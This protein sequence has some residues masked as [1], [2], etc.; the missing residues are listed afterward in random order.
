MCARLIS[1]VAC[2]LLGSSGLL[3]AQPYREQTD[4][5]AVREQGLAFG[6]HMHTQGL[7]IDG[8]YFRQLFDRFQGALHVSAASL[9]DQREVRIS[10]LYASQG[11]K[12]FIYD[13]KNHVYTLNAT[14]SLQRTLVPLN[15]YN[16]LNVIAGLGAGPAI[17]LLKPYY[18]EVAVPI[19]ATQARVELYPYDAS[20]FGYADIVGRA[21]FFQGMNEL[22]T[23]MG[24]RARAFAH[25]NLAGSTLYLR[26]IQLGGTVDVYGRALEIMDEQ[27][28]RQ[29]FANLYLGLLFGNA[30]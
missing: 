30:W 24:F 17:A 14:L 19:N 10:S 25:I 11:G 8:Y 1:F 9:R 12:D 29:V 26:S 22:R 2:L 7:G 4:N 13:K 28:D 16:K 27:P 18:V 20:R 15:H 23:V 5:L 3:C 6:A 21:D